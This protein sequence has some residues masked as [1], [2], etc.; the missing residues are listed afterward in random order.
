MTGQGALSLDAF[1]KGMWR[2]D[3]ELRRAQALAIRAATS[4]SGASRRVGQGRNNLS[5]L[6]FS[7]LDS[8]S[9]INLHNPN[10]WPSPKGPQ[11]RGAPLPPPRPPQR[12][13][14]ILK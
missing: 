3:E 6:N 2:I 10:Q 9:P 5:G 7:S 13:R 1:A 12:A 4:G 11:Q 8:L 14:D